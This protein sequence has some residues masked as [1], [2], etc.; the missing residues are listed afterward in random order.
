QT[1]FLQQ[2]WRDHGAGLEHR[3]ERVEVDHLVF[4]PERVVEAA[5]RDAA[6]QRHLAALEAALEFEARARLRALVPAAGGLAV[7]R[8]LSAAD[9]LA[10]VRGALGRTQ[11]VESHRYSLTSTRCR[12]L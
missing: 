1:A 10:R 8:P 3:A 6:V 11:I 2:L 12:T 5:L 9:P 4:H 7:A